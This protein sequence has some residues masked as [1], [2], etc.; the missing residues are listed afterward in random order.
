MKILL[1]IDGSEC[2]M[3]AVDEVANR[4]WPPGS[5]VKVLSC[6]TV[7][8]AAAPSPFV[9]MQ[10]AYTEWKQAERQHL[11]SVVEDAA[12]RI[13]A[14]TH[15]KVE[16][17]IADGS[18]KEVI[19]EEAENWGADLIVLGSHGYGYVKGFLLGSVSQSVAAHSPCSVE[20]VRAHS[21]ASR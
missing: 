6:V 2:S 14:S 15:L 21:S 19:Q 5:E 12:A 10:P 13:R 4:P 8:I 7:F 16:T 17:L 11:S 3:A 9:G 18:P 20:I 1:A